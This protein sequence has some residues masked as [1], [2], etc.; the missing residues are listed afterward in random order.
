MPGQPQAPHRSGR[1]D[2][3]IRDDGDSLGYLVRSQRIRKGLTQRQLADL[4]TVGV[5]TIRDLEAG[6]TYRPHPQTVHLVTSALGLA[7]HHSAVAVR[8]LP[9]RHDDRPPTGAPPASPGVVL[10]RDD[11]I[12]ALCELLLSS[13]HRLVAVTGFTGVGKTV[14]AA[15]LARLV[16]TATDL[17]VLWVG[18]DDPPDLSDLAVV[19]RRTRP[20]AARH[21]SDPLDAAA[22]VGDEP[23]L[24]IL[25]GIQARG[26]RAAQVEALVNRHQGLRVLTTSRFP[27]GLPAER[28][29]PLVPL[30]L[31]AP[32]VGLGELGKV[33]AVRLFTRFIQQVQP[34]FRLTDANAASVCELCRRFDGI[35]GLLEALAGPFLLFTPEV[36]LACLN[37]DPTGLVTDIVPDIVTVVRDAVSVLEPEPRRLLTD[38]SRPEGDWSV[39]E[40][41]NLLGIAPIRF[42]RDVRRLLELGLVRPSSSVARLRFQVLELVRTIVVPAVPPAR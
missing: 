29:V 28:V 11:E 25:D 16:R 40:A 27:L 15:E 38:L 4:S 24:L 23:C 22:L 34:G 9:G 12:G 26:R 36:L 18:R 5:R 1:I 31:P 17:P 14:L 3:G 33:P 20:P 6:R 13:T 41:A 10:G 21:D 19:L 32:G 7:G 42:A 2:T 37:S 30:A 8:P 35:P 39:E